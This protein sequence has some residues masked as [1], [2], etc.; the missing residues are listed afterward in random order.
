MGLSLTL[1]LNRTLIIVSKARCSALVS[2]CYDGGFDFIAVV[3]G[4]TGFTVEAAEVEEGV[5]FLPSRRGDGGW[6][7]STS[8]LM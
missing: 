7:S 4:T 6:G 1:H 8:S 5:G 2:P 3:T